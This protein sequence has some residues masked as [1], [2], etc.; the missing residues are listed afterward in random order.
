LKALDE[1]LKLGTNGRLRLLTLWS[2]ISTTGNKPL[3]AQLFLGRGVAKAPAVFESALG[4]YL[5]ALNVPLVDHMVTLQGAMGLTAADIEQVLRNAGVQ[6]RAGGAAGAPPQ[7]M[8]TLPNVSL[9]YRH[10]L[11]AKA[12]KLG[13]TDLLTLHKLSGLDPFK[14]LHADPLATLAEDHPFSQTLAFVDLVELL[15]AAGLKVGDVDALI[16]HRLDDTK[17]LR[18]DDGELLVLLKGLADGVQAIR[19]E[20]AVPAD[21][22][23]ISE[24]VLRSKLGLVLAPEV[25]NTFMSM[26]NGNVMYLAT[27]TPGAGEI[28]LVL[29]ALA[30]ASGIVETRH[31]AVAQRPVLTFSR[32][33]ARR[34]DDA[35]S[36]PVSAAGGRC[37]ACAV[38]AIH[39][40]SATGAA[41]VA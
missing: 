30:G 8:L 31:D 9:L 33:P 14:E 27:E 16:R 29:S 38:A 15:R 18:D 1:R 25:A 36:E 21:P 3:Y 26:L 34:P 24:E 39:E 40:S 11:L 6:L 10:A 35:T 2:D 20:H 41:T 4:E 23:D 7:A 12:L 28:P 17:L 22:G 5:S 13:M 19:A 32:C 37:C